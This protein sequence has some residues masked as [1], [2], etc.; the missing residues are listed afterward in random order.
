MLTAM[1]HNGVVGHSERVGIYS[2]GDGDFR[3]KFEFDKPFKHESGHYESE[4]GHRVLMFDA[5]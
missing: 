2:D 3:L 1:E 4:D 5:G